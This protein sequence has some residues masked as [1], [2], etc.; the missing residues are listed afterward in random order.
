MTVKELRA[1]LDSY[2]KSGYDIE[3]LEVVILDESAPMSSRAKFFKTKRNLIS[4]SDNQTC[5]IICASD[6]RFLEWE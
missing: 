5:L 4:L 2:T 1:K 6:E 3:N